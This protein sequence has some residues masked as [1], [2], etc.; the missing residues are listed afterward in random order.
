MLPVTIALGVINFDNVIN[1]IFGTLVSKEAPAAIDRAFRIYMLPQG[2]FSV[3]IATILFPTLSRFATRQDFDGLR[4]TMANGVRLIALMLIPSAVLMMVLA[5][6]ITRLIYQRGVFD[7]EATDLVTQAMVFW[8]LSL[9]AQGISLLFSRTFFSLQRPWITTGISV[10]NMLVNVAVSWLLYKPFGIAGIVLGSV[11]GT[12]TMALLQGQQLS[13]LLH[14]IEGRRSLAAMVKM[15]AASA[16]LAGISYGVWYGL[17]QALGRSLLAQAISLS[18]GIAAGIAVYV[19]TVVLMR[20]DEAQQI[21]RLVGNRF[22]RR[23]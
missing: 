16:L 4:R 6:P 14:G 17:D 20:I 23:D 11:A 13:K 10:A 8:A 3:A 7:A 22:G 12:L 21:R 1:S 15:L 5:Q 19:T 18:L 2:I 9:P